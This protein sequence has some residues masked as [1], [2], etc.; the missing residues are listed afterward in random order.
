M[1][2]ASQQPNSSLHFHGLPHVRNGHWNRRCVRELSALYPSL[3]LRPQQALLSLHLHNCLRQLLI[4]TIADRKRDKISYN[5]SLCGSLSG[6]QVTQFEANVPKWKIWPSFAKHHPLSQEE[7]IPVISHTQKEHHTD[8][9][10]NVWLPKNERASHP[11]GPDHYIVGGT[12]NVPKKKTRRQKIR[13]AMTAEM[14]F[15]LCAR[16][17]VPFEGDTKKKRF[18]TWLGKLPSWGCLCSPERGERGT[19]GPPPRVRMERTC[20]RNILPVL[21]KHTKKWERWQTQW[22]IQVFVWFFKM[23]K[24]SGDLM[25]ERNTKWRGELTKRKTDLITHSQQL[26]KADHPVTRL[27]SV[28]MHPGQQDQC[29][30]CTK[31]EGIKS[32][33]HQRFIHKS[34]CLT[35]GWCISLN[36]RC[37]WRPWQLSCLWVSAW[38]S[39]GRFP[40]HFRTWLL[41]PRMLGW[42]DPRNQ[43]KL[44]FLVPACVGENTVAAGGARWWCLRYGR[45]QRNL[46]VSAVGT[47]TSW[48]DDVVAAH[49]KKGVL[50][51]TGKPF[52]IS[53]FWLLLPWRIYLSSAPDQTTQHNAP[54]PCRHLEPTS[55]QNRNPLFLTVQ[56]PSW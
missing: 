11:N 49:T 31:V 9:I 14:A 6:C 42:L 10:L 28:I 46:L 32:F 27:D 53:D 17:R 22:A 45:N 50:Q 44:L 55:H 16:K 19:E 23:S 3:Q 33:V 51:G 18:W 30:W 35:F 15:L 7:S 34:L 47:D 52:S 24:E 39:P 41:S 4:V 37:G 36:L 1:D 21:Q 43:E 48:P 5:T 56:G 20:T 54:V 12:S 40:A 2:S 38:F 8:W 29:F 26:T 25:Q 13:T